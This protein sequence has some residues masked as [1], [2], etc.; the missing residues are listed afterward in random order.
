M[1]PP[2]RKCRPRT[3]VAP[4]GGAW[5]ETASSHTLVPSSSSVAP[6]GGAW[7]ETAGSAEGEKSESVAPHGGAWIETAS[8]PAY[9]AI[10]RVAPHG[11]AWI[12]TSIYF[13]SASFAFVAPHGGAWIETPFPGESPT[14]AAA[15]PLTEG[16]GLKQ[17]RNMQ[18]CNI[19][20]SRPSR[21]GV[22]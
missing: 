8:S 1:K 10:R 21:R 14:P 11:G 19:A 22:D 7:I 13:L 4:H 3:R 18:A 9:R 6:H 17:R 5:I 12:E 2:S 15:S 16:R 20:Q